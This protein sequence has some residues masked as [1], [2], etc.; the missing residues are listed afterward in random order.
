MTGM[1]TTSA[2]EG[3]ACYF[4]CCQET[5]TMPV[6]NTL[7]DSGSNRTTTVEFWLVK[8]GLLVHTNGSPVHRWSWYIPPIRSTVA[9]AP[10]N[11]PSAVYIKP[12]VVRS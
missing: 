5:M 11:S 10:V 12:S 9:P 3:A 8:L 1:R 2:A 7:N 4:S 6:L